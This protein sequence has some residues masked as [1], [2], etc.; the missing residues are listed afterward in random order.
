MRHRAFTL[1]ELVLVVS[2]TLI[3]SAGALAGLRGAQ[4]WRSAAAVRRLQ[5][6]FTYARNAALLSGRRT[7]CVFDAANGTYEIQQEAGAGQ[8]RITGA[9]LTHPATGQPWRVA[10]A[11][12]AT[13]LQIDV[14]PATNR[15]S[16][17]FD[18]T[19]MPVD[20]NGA[21]LA[22]DL[23]LTCTPGGVIT[24]RAGSGLCEVSW[25]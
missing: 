11:S 21:A 12:L 1:V 8:G 17:G 3:L 4:E 10:L 2:L 6:D 14:S 9:T 22:R 18:G 13:G 25:P 16:F 15:V 7:L 19:G 5:A 20:R 23:T 24:L